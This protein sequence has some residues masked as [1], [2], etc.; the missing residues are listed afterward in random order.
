MNLFFDLPDDIKNYIYLLAYRLKMSDVLIELQTFVYFHEH[1][2][3]MYHVL[4][5]LIEEKNSLWSHYGRIAFVAA[6][7]ESAANNSHENSSDS[8][9]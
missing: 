7:E 1:G 5:E 8:E 2:L 9:Y 3:K 6:R 4:I